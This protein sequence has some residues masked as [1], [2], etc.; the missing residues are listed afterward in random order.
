M[1][2]EIFFIGEPFEFKKGIKIYPPKVKDI[3]TNQFYSYYVKILTYS[4]EEVEDEFVAEK[5]KL[6]KFPTPMEHMLNNCYHNKK[7]ELLCKNAFK[8]FIGEEVTFLYEEKL[9]KNFKKLM[10]SWANKLFIQ[11]M[12]SDPS[13]RSG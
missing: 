1:S 12:Y 2:K 4:Q 3:I 11:L 5:K 8:F 7:Y 6:D 10:K 9:M 13:L